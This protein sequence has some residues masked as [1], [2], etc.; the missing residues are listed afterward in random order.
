MPQTHSQ[1]RVQTSNSNQIL[2]D[3]PLLPS[4]LRRATHGAM[5][6]P[7][8]L[9]SFIPRQN[10]LWEFRMEAPKK[11]SRAFQPKS[12]ASAL[13]TLIPGSS[14]NSLP[15]RRASPSPHL[16]LL[17]AT[18]YVPVTLTAKAAVSSQDQD[19]VSGASGLCEAW[20]VN[21]CHKAKS[22]FSSLQS[23]MFGVDGY[24]PRLSFAEPQCSADVLVSLNQSCD[25]RGG[26]KLACSSKLF[27][28][29]LRVSDHIRSIKITSAPFFLSMLHLPHSLIL[30]ISLGSFQSWSLGCSLIL[31]FII[32]VPLHV[33]PNYTRQHSSLAFGF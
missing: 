3:P 9:S 10:P 31:S 14:G 6:A 16:P 23:E 28:Q 13:L 7:N 32:R 22:T 25:G 4:C 5:L 29:Q 30:S 27:G 2:A 26:A 21:A 33:G 8:P 11:L 1:S 24:P 18:R 19:A 15:W 20:R 12:I 17:T